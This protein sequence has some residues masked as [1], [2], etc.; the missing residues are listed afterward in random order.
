M[1]TTLPKSEE[2]EDASKAPS[3]RKS[4]LLKRKKKLVY[5]VSSANAAMTGSIIDRESTSAAAINSD[6]QTEQNQ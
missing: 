2:A 6:R 1:D 3:E 5:V 4:H